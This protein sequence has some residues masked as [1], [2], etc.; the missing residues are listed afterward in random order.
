MRLRNGSRG[1]IPL[2][3]LWLSLALPL[4]GANLTRGPYVQLGT[5]SSMVV[6]WRTDAA[7]NSRVR[8]GT[9]PANLN[10]FAD[11]SSAVTEHE[12]NVTGLAA[13]TRY[14]YSVGSTTETLVSGPD[15]FFVTSPVTA[16]P[17]R[18]WVAG[19]TRSADANE[20]AVR[21]A[22]YRLAGSRHTDL[23]LMLGDNAGYYGTE[24]DFQNGLFG[25]FPELLR[26]SVL[27]PARGN[28]DADAAVYYG[29]HT[30][31]TNGEAGGVPSGTEAYY[32][33]DYGNI[34]FICLDTYGS[35]VAASSPQL[36]W[37]QNDLN[38]T[39]K[40]WIIVFFHH[41][42]YSHGGHNSDTDT[43]MTAV[44]QNV[45]PILE[46]RGVDLVLAGHSHNYERSYL[47]DG[48]YGA[49]STFTDSMKKDGGSGRPPTVY[50][51]Q[52]TGVNPHE[53]AVYVV[54]GTSGL[55][56]GGALDYPAMYF[57]ESQLGSL[58][59]DVN[60]QTLDAKF[61]RETGALDD[62][63]T[64][65]KG[66]KGTT[67]APAIT[68]PSSPLPAGMVSTPYAATFTANGDAPITWSVTAGSLPP[69][70]T[71]HPTGVYLGT[72]TAAGTYNFTVTASNVPPNASRT[73]THT[74]N[75]LTQ[76]PLNG[77]AWLV[78]GAIQAEDHDHGGPGLA[79]SDT[80]STNEGG[81][82]RSGGVDIEFGADGAAGY[83]VSWTKAGEWLEYTVNVVSAGVHTL[84]A[85]VASSGSGGT[86]HVEFGGVNKTGTMAVPNTGGWQTWQTITSS[87][88]TLSAGQ[89]VMRVALDAVGA[90]GSIGNF[91]WL[92][93]ALVAQ[94][95][96]APT[97]LVATA[98]SASQINLRWTDN[99]S[100]ETGF[101][102]ER[103]LDAASFA[104]IATVGA[105]VTTYQNTGLAKNRRY[106]YRVRAY[107]AAGA[108]PYSNVANTRTL[109][110]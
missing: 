50:N 90:T 86:F 2:F 46:A 104:R 5:P 52:H 48:H 54:A 51:K 20:L 64:I 15:F 3:P 92:R 88:F 76:T 79:Y 25:M 16:K 56:A 17:T 93:I 96:A 47:I 14:Y 58:V 29:A 18:V 37:L 109:K 75:A 12:V 63:F 89:Q 101:E 35:S 40:D 10:L 27:W 95:P 61:L 97:N 106:Y 103:S 65:I 23:W 98:V 45:V 81:K 108:S 39:S 94:T 72:P 33:F 49:S 8:Y 44:R 11:L 80:T 70:M 41:A 71:L 66:P 26:N 43:I 91:N 4:C 78:P 84:E 110:K 9:D 60:G 36:L 74:I 6:R 105:N 102:I 42:P 77:T 19:D 99:A 55:V 69:G 62:W 38:A 30:L 73:Y 82:Y 28:H 87:V 67:V 22:Y 100:N 34:H 59:L 107:N 85:R 53:G 57:S 21:D 83:D 13:N 24:A 1:A 68:G 32:S 31:P 7:T